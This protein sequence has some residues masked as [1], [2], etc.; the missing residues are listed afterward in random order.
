MSIDSAKSALDTRQQYPHTNPVSSAPRQLRSRPISQEFPE[1][2]PI[3]EKPRHGENNLGLS[4]L[5]IEEK[6]LILVSQVLLL[7]YYLQFYL[8]DFIE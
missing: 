4:S 8:N 3:Q 2:P 1:I 5:Q 6:Y 7:V